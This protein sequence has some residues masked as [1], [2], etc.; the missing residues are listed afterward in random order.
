MR[1]HWVTPDPE[2]VLGLWKLARPTDPPTSHEAAARVPNFLRGHFLKIVNALA[3]G[4]AGQTEIARRAGLTVQQ[5][6]RRLKKLRQ[7]GAIERTGRVV[8]GGES[9]YRRAT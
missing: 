7:E 9:E 3:G 1:P 2:E 5:V 4:P 6:S 8:G